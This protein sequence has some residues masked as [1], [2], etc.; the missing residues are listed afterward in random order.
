MAMRI[1][2][3]LSAWR[4]GFAIAEGADG[5]QVTLRGALQGRLRIATDNKS[6]PCTVKL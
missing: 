6:W 2:S 5:A 3:K 1:L 4:L